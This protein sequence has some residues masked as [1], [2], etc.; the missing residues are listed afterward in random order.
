MT[1]RIVTAI[2]LLLLVALIG[3]AD[4][5]YL[6]WAFLGITFLIA[7]NE[8]MALFRLKSNSPYFFA[9]LLW[10]GALFYRN[11][12]DLIVVAAL[13]FGALLAYHGKSSEKHGLYRRLFLPWL[14]P[15]ASFLFLF[16][17]YRDYGMIAL[18]WLLA[19]VALTDTFAFVVGKLIGRTPFSPSSPNKS[20]EGVIGGILVGTAGGALVGMEIL[21]LSLALIISFMTAIASVFGDL[22]ESY[23]K[24]DA[25]V[26]DSGKILPGH[27]GVLD[28]VDGYL[29]AAPILA[30]LL[31]GIV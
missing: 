5:L 14:Y 21:P 8:A 10:I 20:L 12:D 6:T 28:R 3:W 29:F 31:R 11:P 15:T 19:V 2:A 26:K 18:G 4:N 22:F 7:F 13:F 24:R 30:I 23:L 27:G 9:L 1:Q 17:L 16:T 25:G